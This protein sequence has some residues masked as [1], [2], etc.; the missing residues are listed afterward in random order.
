MADREPKDWI[1][2]NGNH[3]PI[4]EGQ[5]KAE[6]VKAFEKK[7]TNEKPVKVGKKEVE[8]RKKKTEHMTADDFNKEAER[9]GIDITSDD[10]DDYVTSSYG[11]ID[12]GDK[13][14]KFIDNA[15]DDM[16]VKDKVLYRGLYFN[17]K[18]E[19]E[20]FIK[21]ADGHPPVIESRRDGLSWSTDESVADVFGKEAGEYSVTLVNEDDEHN[22][23]SIKGFADT[24]GVSSSEVLYS[25]SSDF[26]IIDSE[27]DGKH[28]T[29]YVTQTPFT[30]PKYKKR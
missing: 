23:I 19:F 26:E 29:L 24:P 11:G 4:Y 3:I 25:S 14:S 9:Q 20:N 8:V 21:K 17:S 10:I 15:P 1:T 12:L 7:H 28:A 6:V 30:K 18:Q 5:T 2:I 16:K 13:V 27:V 22:A